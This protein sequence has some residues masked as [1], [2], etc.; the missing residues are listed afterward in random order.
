MQFYT[1]CLQLFM[2]EALGLCQEGEGGQLIDSAEW[3]N[4]RNG[5]RVTTVCV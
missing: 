5:E 2:Y 4:N 1:Y 3:I